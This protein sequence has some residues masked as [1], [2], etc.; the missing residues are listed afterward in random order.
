M[1][2]Q[3]ARAQAGDVELRA[4]NG[5][6]EST[7]YY[8]VDGSEPNLSGAVLDPQAPPLLYRTKCRNQILVPIRRIAEGGKKGEG[9]L[10]GANAA[11]G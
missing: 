7:F 10:R 11:P 8:T 5:V 4:R 6:P 3:Q 2:C 9:G 1:L